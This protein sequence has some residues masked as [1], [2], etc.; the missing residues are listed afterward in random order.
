MTDIKSLIATSSKTNEINFAG[1]KFAP[2]AAADTAAK[3]DA[4]LAVEIASDRYRDYWAQK[5]FGRT[6]NITVCADEKEFQAKMYTDAL[7]KK[8]GWVL[9]NMSEEIDNSDMKTD[10]D[11]AEWFS[12]YGNGLNLYDKVATLPC[13]KILVGAVK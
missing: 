10:E 12:T 8:K 11:Y 13:G 3:Q 7:A 5:V 9:S 2:K 6:N 4:E 1:Y